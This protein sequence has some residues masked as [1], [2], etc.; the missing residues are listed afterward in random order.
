[1]AILL[2]LTFIAAPL[3]VW[4]FD[5]FGLPTNALMILSALVIAIALVRIFVKEELEKF[6]ES[7][8]KTPRWLKISIGGLL[9]AS[10]ISLFAFDLNPSKLAQWIVLY[11]EPIIL[12]YIIK[13]YVQ[14]H[15]EWREHYI[16]S[17]YVVL[18]LIG[19]LCLAQFFTLWQLP[20][21]FWGNSNEPKRA[22][23]V[24][25][26]PNGLGLFMAP[27]LAWLL[28]DVWQRI[29]K[30][31][32][33]I[34]SVN[35]LLVFG[36]LLGAAG[37][38]L[39]LSRGAWLGFAAACVVFAILS[40]NKKIIAS[41]AII[42]IVVAGIV[43]AVPNLRYRV[44]LPFYGEKS[45]VARLS[46]WQTGGK[47]IKDSP[48]LGK[49]VNGFKDN[50]D[51]YNTDSGLEHYNFPHN[52]ILN[53]WIDSGLLG[54]ISMFSILA[55]AV[56]RGWRNRQTALKLGMLLFVVAVVVH[57]LIDIPYFKNDLAMMFWTIFAL[58][59]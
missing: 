26:H 36:W 58:S 57:G 50:W 43:A 19:A 52:I 47:M 9:L 15:P 23:G 56:W 14:K 2:L 8:V 22:I 51:R 40:A 33:Q 53:F 45:A 55:F 5:V 34:K 20:Q 44:L 49:G 11:A 37:M 1:M 25:A 28:P 31:R 12:F 3:Y 7:V 29:S 42:F 13:Y 32:G 6:W 41:L 48:V 4:R 59:I 18:G 24:F 38:F 46:L 54:L 27:L 17:A 10:L 21:D 30:V 35:T 16:T 39:S